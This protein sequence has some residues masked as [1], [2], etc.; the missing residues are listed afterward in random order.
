M[1]HLLLSDK[2]KFAV[3]NFMIDNKKFYI[4]QGDTLGI[5]L[6]LTWLVGDEMESLSLLLKLFP[7]DVINKEKSCEKTAEKLISL[8]HDKLYLKSFKNRINIS[9]DYAIFSGIRKELN[10]KGMKNLENKITCCGSHDGINLHKNGQKK[11][12]MDIENND[13]SGKMN[14]YLKTRI[15]L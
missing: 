7:C 10:K 4:C 2:G 5:L 15:S 1:L 8:V 3:A 9:C 6:R 11:I 12:L 14:K 13:G